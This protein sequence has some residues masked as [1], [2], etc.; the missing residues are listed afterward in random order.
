MFILLWTLIF[1]SIYCF[2]VNS[3][4]LFKFQ[5]EF[6]PN[7]FLFDYLCLNFSSQICV[8]VFYKMICIPISILFYEFILNDAS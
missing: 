5:I 4:S 7:I 1:Y 8:N 3:Y 6:H 2:N